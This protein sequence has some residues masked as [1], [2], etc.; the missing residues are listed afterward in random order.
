MPGDPSHRELDTSAVELLPQRVDRVECGQVDLDV[1]LGVEDEPLHRI[2]VGVDGRDGATAE[3]LGIGEEQ[4]CVVAVD[5]QAGFQLRVRVILDVVHTGHPGNEAEHAVMWAGHPPQQIQDR[6]S[7]SGEHPVE[8]TQ[9]QHRHRG[10]QGEDQLAAAKTR[11][12][13]KAGDIDQ[14]QCRVDH[15]SRQCC[16]RETGEQSVREQQDGNQQ[17]HRHQG[18]HLGASADHFSQRRP[19]CAGTHRKAMAHSGSDIAQA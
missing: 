18:V 7:D 11:Q 17:T 19:A 1:G 9:A 10:E 12:S 6:Q 3:V 16:G 5:Q 2:R 15:Q 14:S 4:R 8:H 13:P